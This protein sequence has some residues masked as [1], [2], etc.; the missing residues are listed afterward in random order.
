[1]ALNISLYLSLYN[2]VYMVFIVSPVNADTAICVLIMVVS[3]ELEIP[4]P[5]MRSRKRMPNCW[6]NANVT[7]WRGEWI[8]EWRKRGMSEY[9]CA[10]R[11]V[12]AMVTHN[13]NATGDGHQPAPSAV[14]RHKIFTQIA[15][16]SLFFRWYLLW[17][18]SGG[19]GMSMR[20]WR[21]L[22]LAGWSILGQQLLC[23]LFR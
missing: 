12:N 17:H 15:L 7:S 14:G 18:R 13:V 20:R 5:A 10:D 8:W 9:L 4:R 21:Y 23:L 3:S 2:L 22:G 6:A 11:R 16:V 1:M 19:Y